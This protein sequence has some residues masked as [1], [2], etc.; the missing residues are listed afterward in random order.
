MNGPKRRLDIAGKPLAVWIA[1]ICG[2]AAVLG[3][4]HLLQD[5]EPQPQ[6]VEVTQSPSGSIHVF[7]KS[8]VPLLN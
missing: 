3:V 2:L 1:G 5:V 8:T 7:V 6:Q 4:A